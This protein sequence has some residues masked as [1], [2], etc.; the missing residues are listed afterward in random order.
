ME[1][2]RDDLKGSINNSEHLV[3]KMYNYQEIIDKA[4]AIIAIELE[5]QKQLE[6]SFHAPAEDPPKSEQQPPK[7]FNFGSQGVGS[8]PYEFGSNTNSQM[9]G[10]QLKQNMEF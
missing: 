7:D 5:E 3:Q 9:F 8:N 10:T 4:L 1:L 6:A 2:F